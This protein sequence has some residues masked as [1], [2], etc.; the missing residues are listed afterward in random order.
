MKQNNQKK[1]LFLDNMSIS[2]LNDF[3]YDSTNFKKN[4]FFLNKNPILINTSFSDIFDE[5]FNL[6]NLENKLNEAF[7]NIDNHNK[8]DFI[9]NYDLL[10]FNQKESCKINF[11]FQNLKPIFLNKL[12][13]KSNNNEKFNI[14]YLKLKTK[15]IIESFKDFKDKI[16]KFLVPEN[17]GIKTPE[18]NF[19]ILNNSFYINK[20]FNYI[21]FLV[22][23]NSIFIL[24]PSYFYEVRVPLTYLVFKT[25]INLKIS[26]D[27]LNSQYNLNDLYLSIGENFNTNFF[28]KNLILKSNLITINSFGG[29][30]E[31]LNWVKS[32]NSLINKD[33][34]L[35]QDNIARDLGIYNVEFSK[36]VLDRIYDKSNSDSIIYK[37][38][39]NAKPINGF[40]W[41]DG[42]KSYK[43]INIKSI[44]VKYQETK[45]KEYIS[46]DLFK[47]NENSF[48]KECEI[49]IKS[50]NLI[51]FE[52]N[53]FLINEYFVEFQKGLNSWNDPHY[54]D[55]KKQFIS[56]FDLLIDEFKKNI[57]F[58][59]NVSDF[60]DLWSNYS[61]NDL[62]FKENNVFDLDD[63]KFVVSSLEDFKNQINNKFITNSLNIKEL[64]KEYE[65]EASYG[66]KVDLNNEFFIFFIKNKK[67]NEIKQLRIKLSNLKLAPEIYLNIMFNDQLI[68]SI[69]LNYFFTLISNFENN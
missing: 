34:E 12:P 15:L 39:F 57:K 40:K 36:P 26:A 13:L 25:K 11:K 67:T 32:E 63:N 19:K 54:S 48:N 38:T 50:N 49:K 37:I 28:K 16:F 51:D 52:T 23:S 62:P 45:I 14:L 2:F 9:L 10:S 69:K 21:S 5:N 31:K 47:F 18:I 58:E 43:K 8:I 44:H 60:N 20:E 42:S 64:N 41:C 33:F 55:Y 61:K 29:L 3:E 22:E 30:F 7:L 65:V 35:L 59:F 66:Y 68:R 1:L 46:N 24:E 56:N 4:S 17:L 53:Y 6:T 27:N